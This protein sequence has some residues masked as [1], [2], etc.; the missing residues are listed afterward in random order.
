MKTRL[1]LLLLAVSIPAAAQELAETW[2]ESFVKAVNT[3][4][5]LPTPSYD[6][7]RVPGQIRVLDRAAIEASG[8]RTLQ[9]LLVRQPGVVLYDEIGNG[10]QQTLDLRGFNAT[11]IPTT[12]VL[13]DGVRI[14][15]QDFGT[16][17][18]QTIPLS[19]IEKIE[20]L[21]GPQT[22]FG[23]NALAGVISISSRKG[24]TKTRGELQAEAGSFDRQR[25]AGAVSGPLGPLARCSLAASRQ[26]EHGY[27]ANSA[28][29]LHGFDGKLDYDDGDSQVG[30]AYHYADDDLKQAGSL[31]ASEISVDRRQNV[32]RVESDSLAHLATLDARRRVVDGLSAS[33]NAFVRER[34][35]NT[36]LNKGRT[37]ISTSRSEM[38]THGFT[39]Q[40]EHDAEVLG[41]RHIFTAGGES[42]YGKVNSDSSGSFGAFPFRTGSFSRD[43]QLGLF[44]QET[45]DL[46]PDLVAL[47]GGVRW[48][49]DS[50][51]FED[52]TK[53]A[54]NGG[55]AYHRASP[56]VGV[57]VNPRPWLQAYASFAD[58]F[59]T[60]TP[61][62]ITA[63][64]PFASTPFLKPV[65]SRTAELGARVKRP[66]FEAT[67][68]IYRTV[69][70]DEIY[71]VFDPTAGFGQNRNINKTRRD[72]LEATLEPRWGDKADGF[73]RYGYTEAT[74]Q[75]DFVLDKVPFGNTQE[76]HS[77]AYIPEVPRHRL[78]VGA[79][80]HPA[81]GWTLSAD[82]QCWSSVYLFGDEGNMERRL[83]GV[84][85]A[86]AGASYETGGLR[87]FLRG[88]N[89]LD[90]KYETR[91]ILAT[92][93]TT[94]A[95]DRFLIPAPGVTLSG[96]VRWRFE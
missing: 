15:E 39:A 60:P 2:T 22:L 51:Q 24:G 14:N 65:K 95:A 79:G 78:A 87:L 73:V 46:W 34:L 5:R 56:R 59:R 94:S 57:N 82:E 28:A 21:P 55:R 47:T 36:P 1:P 48:D 89:V 44:A 93:P 29:R 58:A 7:S 19:S 12:V 49:R 88:D 18:W 11:P 81:K 4:S 74:F 75:T 91:G 92:N 40:L 43:R 35:Q 68:A 70:K 96:G 13:L 31:T 26:T 77:G 80:V 30:F 42:S 27:R 76:V 62:E 84:C 54:N 69:T 85:V 41:R 50:L 33:A 90:R 20:I 25:Y 8:A 72:G 32:S 52:K 38:L 53:A 83:G 66:S 67:L 10:Y 63:L 61:A 17:N 86:G 6:S 3:A 9:D 45:F 64:G 71:A 37:S 23:K 16:I